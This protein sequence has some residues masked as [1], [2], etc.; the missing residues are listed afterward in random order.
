MPSLRRPAPVWTA[1]AVVSFA[2][3]LLAGTETGENVGAKVC[4]TCHPSQFSR[5]TQSA[6]AHALSRAVDHPL[7]NTFPTALAMR[8]GP[9]YRFDFSR[10]AGELRTRI[11]DAT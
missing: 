6:H 9:N 1:C 5:Q 7:A 8:R 11:F 3:R 4:G 10:S 2:G